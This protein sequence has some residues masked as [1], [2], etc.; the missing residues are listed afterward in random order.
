M[1]RRDVCIETARSESI[2]DIYR[3]AYGGVNHEDLT[4][5]L[6]FKYND[7]FIH[8][9]CN[10]NSDMRAFKNKCLKLVNRIQYNSIIGYN[11]SST[12]RS[13]TFA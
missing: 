6:L 4:L 12:H 13:T 1:N 2:S 8:K 3:R 7:V 11:Y 5:L 10:R 9:H